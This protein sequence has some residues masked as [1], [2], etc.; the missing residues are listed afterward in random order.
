VSMDTVEGPPLNNDGLVLVELAEG[1]VDQSRET[2]P[3]LDLNLTG[4]AENPRGWTATRIE[5]ASAK[6]WTGPACAY[7]TSGSARVAAAY[8]GALAPPRRIGRVAYSPGRTVSPSRRW[9][10]RTPLRCHEVRQ[11]VVVGDLRCIY[12]RAM[13]SARLAA[14]SSSVSRPSSWSLTSLRRMAA[15]SSCCRSGGACVP[16]MRL[17]LTASA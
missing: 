15:T 8:P 7:R 5:T 17:N 4:Y 6:A 1:R 11:G 16:V 14:S 13:T 12:I 10:V 9:V 3:L 2:L